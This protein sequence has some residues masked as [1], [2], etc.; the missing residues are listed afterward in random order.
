MASTLSF[1][2]VN[3]NGGELLKRCLDSIVR[4]PPSIPFDIWVVDNASTDGSREWLRSAETDAVPAGTKLQLIENSENRGFGNANNQAFNETQSELLFLLNPDAQVTAGACDRLLETLGSDS[5]IGA[6]GP[7]LLNADGSIQISVWRNPPTAWATLVS[8][9][10]LASLLP[11]RLRGELLLAEHWDHNTRRD[12]PMLGGAAIL[13]RRE[14]IVQIGGFD[15]RFHMYGEDNEWC[16]RITRGGWRIVFEPQA[17]VI[18][19]GA[20]GSLQRW[21]DMEKLKVQT[22]AYLK[23][24]HLAVPRWQ[25]ITNLAASSMLLALQYIVR[26]L[27][28]RTLDEV[29][30]VLQMQFRDFRQTLKGET[31]K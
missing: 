2:I 27:R 28:R 4:Y 18:H 29:A 31:F 15:E 5:R 11:R 9:L 23:F 30:L 12:V 25:V 13:V 1:I 3:W 7:Q 6:C 20:H 8:G 14:V 21:T 17:V 10:R 26:R 16:L 19:Q 22:E 24:L